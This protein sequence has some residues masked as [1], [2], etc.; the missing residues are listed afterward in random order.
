RCLVQPGDER[1]VVHSMLAHR[2][3]DAGDPQRT[4]HAFPVA[5]IAVRILAR[6]HHRLLGDAIDVAAAATVTACGG[7]DFLV[8]R[9]RR[10]STLY[11]GHLALLTRMAA[12]P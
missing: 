10:Y 2:R 3:V 7:K 11:S 12:T 4:E 8:A 9:A 1:A 6:L 5:A